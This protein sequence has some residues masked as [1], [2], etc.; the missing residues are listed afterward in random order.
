MI[1][2]PCIMVSV[3]HSFLSFQV[4]GDK[5]WDVWQSG[6]PCWKISCLFY[7]RVANKFYSQRQNIRCTQQGG[8]ATLKKRGLVFFV[9]YLLPRFTVLPYLWLKKVLLILISNSTQVDLM[10]K[11]NAY[12]RSYI[13]YCLNLQ[14]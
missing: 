7:S 4:L 2:V 5:L 11:P 10:L 12:G 1:A 14:T 13:N 9:Y 8:S 3:L 6:G